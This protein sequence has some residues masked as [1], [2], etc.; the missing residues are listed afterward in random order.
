[1]RIHLDRRSPRYD[2]AVTSTAGLLLMLDALRSAAV[3]MTLYSTQ[4]R[5]T[6]TTR[7]C[8]VGRWPTGHGWWHAP[9]HIRHQWSYVP[10]HRYLPRSAGCLGLGAVGLDCS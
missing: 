8:D 3:L 7:S 6:W 1:M 4:P 9:K 10:S 2:D 5:A